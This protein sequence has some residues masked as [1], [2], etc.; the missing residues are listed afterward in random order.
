MCWTAVRQEQR[1]ALQYSS[2]RFCLQCTPWALPHQRENSVWHGAL[3]SR[4]RLGL[5]LAAESI[6]ERNQQMEILF[7]LFSCSLHIKYRKKK[8][9]QKSK[10]KLFCL[11]SHI[12]R[13]TRITKQ[14]L[15]FWHSI[16]FLYLWFSF[17]FLQRHISH[18]VAC[19]LTSCFVDFLLLFL[20]LVWVYGSSFK[21]LCSNCVMKT[22]ITS[23]EVIM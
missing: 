4:L 7:L 21:G 18:F 10:S 14:C 19:Y 5:L 2:L 3:D 11:R 23:C 20:L 13:T 16:P 8:Q 17:L 22:I 9:I 12:V 1:Q 6:E 15:E